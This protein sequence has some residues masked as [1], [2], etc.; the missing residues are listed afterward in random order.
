MHDAI[1]DLYAYVLLLDG[2]WHRLG[3]RLEELAGSGSTMAECL[4]L[5]QSRAD[6][7]EEVA[8]LRATIATLRAEAEDGF[9]PAE[10]GLRP[11]DDGG[12]RL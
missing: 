11:A 12:A 10:D 8:A 9:T 2:E 1:T 5:E 3:V 7:A 4:T 6:I